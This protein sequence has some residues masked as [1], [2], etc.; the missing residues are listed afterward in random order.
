MQFESCS[1]YAP[2]K[3]IAWKVN[4]SA[5]QKFQSRYS[6][7]FSWYC[8]YGT[9]I[10]INN[11]IYC[12]LFKK[13]ST[14]FYYD[15]DRWFF[16]F[17]V[18]F[19]SLPNRAWKWHD[20]AIPDRSRLLPKSPPLKYGAILDVSTTSKAESTEKEVKKLQ[21]S[22]CKSEFKNSFYVSNKH[23]SF[24]SHT[25]INLWIWL[26]KLISRQNILL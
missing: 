18:L 17:V 11:P 22:N 24:C 21:K 5:D 7:L 16:I 25:V 15:D 20:N 8:L 4:H 13:T 12:F 1:R 2:V 14:H 23:C 10:T 6:K 9:S 26:S 19:C 3:S